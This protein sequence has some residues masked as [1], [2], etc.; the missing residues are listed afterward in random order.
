MDAISEWLTHLVDHLGYLGIFFATLIE[1]TF[2]PIPAE[3][4]MIPAGMLAAEGK[5]NYWI[6]LFASTMGVIVG[7]FINYWVGIRFGRTWVLRYGKY[8]MIKHHHVEKTDYF[9]ARYGSLAVFIGRLLPGVRHY[10]AFIAGVAAMRLR[11]F[12]IYTAL[13]G[14]IWMWVLLQIGYMTQK[15]VEKGNTSI[16]SLET[17]MIACA[18]L[19]V[20]AFFIQRWMINHKPDMTRLKK[21]QNKDNNTEEQ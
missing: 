7:S 14:M 11:P 9:F 4:T 17:V 21:H 13:G 18:I 1:S 16:S 8:L 3:V 19:G 2:V 5:L 20:V 10:I 12:I 6:L 15:Q